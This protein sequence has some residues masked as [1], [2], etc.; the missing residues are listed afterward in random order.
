[1][2]TTTT[3]LGLTKPELSEQFQLST[4][5]GNS[6]ILDAFAGQTNTA[7]AGKASAADLTKTTA[8]T[9][10]L[11][12][13]G[14]KNRL[15]ITLTSI[16]ALNTAGTWS[17]NAYTRHGITFTV[18]SDLTITVAQTGQ[19]TGNSWL[20]L[21]GTQTKFLNLWGTGC[22]EGGGESTFRI[23]YGDNRYDEG[24][25][26]AVNSGS[27][28]IVIMSGYDATAGLTFKP[29]VCTVAD[30]AVS[31]AYAQYCPTMPELY[32]MILALGGGNR[33]VQEAPAGEEER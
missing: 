1:M 17:G 33:S 28:G 11:I 8:A 19:R 23:Q 25:G 15:D 32:A 7:L 13:G 24:S 4:W 2:S 5:N 22:P 6:D 21:Y 16:K 31:Q 3:N 29:M 20:D 18:N 9:T 14:S 26:S 27:I 30:W 12:D 10:Q